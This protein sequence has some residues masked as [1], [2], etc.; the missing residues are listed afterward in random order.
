MSNIL[1]SLVASIDATLNVQQSAEAVKRIANA[2]QSDQ[3]NGLKGKSKATLS[4]VRLSVSK[5]EKPQEASWSERVSTSYKSSATP[6]LAL[7]AALNHFADGVKRGYYNGNAVPPLT[8][9][10]RAWVNGIVTRVK[11]ADS[12]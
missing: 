2:I 3:A 5:A 11:N 1:N 7:Q 12:E 8:D 4:S 10:I 6:A 9:G